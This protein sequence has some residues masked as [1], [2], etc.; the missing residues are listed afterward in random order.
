[1]CG[2]TQKVRKSNKRCR[3]AKCIFTRSLKLRSP[4][5]HEKWKGKDRYR[6]PPK[7]LLTAS[8]LAPTM[9]AS[10]TKALPPFCP[11]AYQGPSPSVPVL[12]FIYSSSIRFVCEK[13]RERSSKARR[14]EQHY[15]FPISYC[16]F[17]SHLILHPYFTP[18]HPSSFQI[19]RYSY[20]R[21]FQ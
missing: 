6:T 16:Q 11:Y 7:D 14:H 8:P 10:K 5:Y 9:Y 19:S 12:F 20:L 2:V 21:D 4:C 3:I 17:I 18:I 1:M 13:N 15:P